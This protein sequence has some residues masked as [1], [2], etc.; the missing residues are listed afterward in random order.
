MTFGY[1]IVV[2]E[3]ETIDYLKLTELILITCTFES[4]SELTPS[5]IV[6]LVS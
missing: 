4:K 5:R 6:T 1:L 2:A 3:H